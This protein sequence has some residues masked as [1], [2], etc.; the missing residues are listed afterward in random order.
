MRPLTSGECA[1][2]IAPL[3]GRISGEDWAVFRAKYV[4]GRKIEGMKVISYIEAGSDL[5]D[6][7]LLRFGK[8][9]EFV[10]LQ[11][12]RLRESERPRGEALA[13]RKGVP[14]AKEQESAG[15]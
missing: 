8:I 13:P 12:K 5:Q 2:D 7:V 6:I 9:D 15:I 3:L 10:E 4:D 11:N 14:S 1:I